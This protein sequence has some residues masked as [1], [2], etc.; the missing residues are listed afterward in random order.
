MIIER[1]NN[2]QPGQEIVYYTGNLAADSTIYGGQE[3]LKG[4]S[5]QIA[6]IRDT[7]YTLYNR[8]KLLLVQRKASGCE[9]FTPNTFD[10]IAVGIGEKDKA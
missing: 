1:L 5:K 9:P 3:Q 2:I 4:Y 10:Y 6:K 8:G 7:A